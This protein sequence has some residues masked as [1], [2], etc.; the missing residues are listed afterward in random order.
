MGYRRHGRTT[1]D[2]YGS[3]AYAPVYDGTAVRVPQW[4]EELQQRRRPRAW[5]REQALTRTQVQVREAGQVAPFAVAGFL[6]VAV[7]AALLVFSYVQLTVANGEMTALRSQLNTLQTEHATLTAQYEKVFDMATI[8][9]AVGDTMVRP[10]GDQVIYIDLSEPDTVEV[11][12]KETAY[13]GPLG[14]LKSAGEVLGEIF[15]YFR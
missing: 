15:E 3:M 6:A 5:E 2:T 9:A 7:M 13:R 14:A 11:Y 10:T 4:G 1:Y 8:E 12:G